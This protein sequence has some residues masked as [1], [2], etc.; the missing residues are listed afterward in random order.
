MGKKYK[1]SA[2]KLL[3]KTEVEKDHDNRTFFCSELVAASYKRLGYLPCSKSAAQYWPGDFA[4]ER[5]LKLINAN[6]GSEVLIDFSI[7]H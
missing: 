7:P 6:L 2:S 1:V 5:D 4:A 3:K